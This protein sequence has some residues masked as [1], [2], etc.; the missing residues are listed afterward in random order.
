MLDS[1]T[2]CSLLL[3]WTEYRCWPAACLVLHSAAMLRQKKCLAEC[4]CLQ[5]IPGNH[6][7]L[8]KGSLNKHRCPARRHLA[9]NVTHSLPYL[10]AEIETQ[11][12]GQPEQFFASYLARFRGPY[13]SSH[14]KLYYSTDVGAAHVVMLSECGLP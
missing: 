4:H 10:P 1:T 13:N 3:S 6:G 12:D 9:C 7:E 8:S 14:S 5:M 11:A 2:A